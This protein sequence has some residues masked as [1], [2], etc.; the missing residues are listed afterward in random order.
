MII[1]NNEHTLEQV[2]GNT[3][4]I[5]T[6]FAKIPVYK[7]DERN[8]IMIDSGYGKRDCHILEV[9]EQNNLHVQAVL[10]SHFH[11]DHVGNHYT[12]RKKYGAKLYMTPYAEVMC[13]SN[14]NIASSFL[15]ASY[16][17]ICASG[18]KTFNAD[19]LIRDEEEI[20]VCG[21]VFK[22]LQLPGHAPEHIGF[23]TPDG[24]GYLGDAILSEQV[25]QLIRMPY[26]TCCQLDIE[27]MK[28]IADMDL[29]LCILGHNGIT[30]DVKTLAKKNLEKMYG[31]LDIIE[32]LADH[33]M[34]LEQLSVAA[35]NH[36]GID[37][38]S[39]RKI[40]GANHNVKAFTDYL[41]D[42]GRL[43]CAAIDGTVQYIKK[44]LA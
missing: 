19:V 26:T 33:Y 36:Y 12:L 20:T 23:I 21:A 2:R 39:I 41:L 5:S 43:A 16:G 4:C 29:D 44:D 9:L 24:V 6:P 11:P 37:Q 15:G 22:V 13:S 42:T 18:R 40:V 32:G 35:M 31:V 3:Y 28:K 1:L 17:R 8:V 27:S 30:E 10:T 14:E 38:T 7:L 34:T 25:L